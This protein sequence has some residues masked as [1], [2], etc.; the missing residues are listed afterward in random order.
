MSKTRDNS[1]ELDYFELRRRH[2][3]YKRA[4]SAPQP[5][6]NSVE[7]RLERQVAQQKARPEPVAAEQ[8]PI[9]DVQ[10]ELDVETKAAPMDAFEEAIEENYEAYEDDM[11]YDE[12][13]E[14]ELANPNPFD[15]FI[16]FFNGMKSNMASRR[17]KDDELEDLD[18]EDLTDEELAELEAEGLEDLD[19]DFKEEA[20]AP[21]KPRFSLRRNV[22]PDAEDDED[23]IAPVED[24]ED[25][26]DLPRPARKAAPSIV[27][28]DEDF[29]D[30]DFDDLDDEDFDD[31][32]FDDEDFDEEDFDEE[33]DAPRKGGFK[34]FVNLFVTR[35]DE[36][37]EFD[38]DDEELEDADFDD[39]DDEDLEEIEE[40]EAPVR[41]G[42]FS[43]VRKNKARRIEEDEEIYDDFSPEIQIRPE[44]GQGKMDEMNKLANETAAPAD[45]IETSGMSRRERRELAMRLAAEEAARKAEE[46]ALAKAAAAPV[47]PLFTDLE[48]KPAPVDMAAFED[49]PETD[50]IVETT[51]EEVTETVDEPT[52]EFTPVSMR[53]VQEAAEKA[54]FD[55]D[56]EEEDPDDEDEDDEDE[57]IVEK[58]PRRGLFGR[59]RAKVEDEDEED[60]DDEDDEDDDED[61]DDEEEEI[62]EKK[63]RRGLFGRKRAKDEDED[64]EDDFD[65][66]D[67]DDEDLD[68][69]EDDEYDEYD[70]DEDDDDYGD[71]DDDDEYDDDYD[72]DDDED[73]PRRSFGHHLIGVFKIILGLILVLLIVVIGLNFHYFITGENAVV[74]KAHEMLGDSSAS[75]VLC[76]GYVMREAMPAEETAAPEAVIEAEITAEPT[77][78]PQVEADIPDLDNNG[79]I[80]EAPVV[81]AAPVIEAVPAVGEAP[82]ASGT[83]G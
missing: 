75:D 73:E 23:E 35:V 42:F 17:Q 60:L 56:G 63:P 34:K 47:E 58:K 62:V 27:D 37:E 14:E 59:K 16:R 1:P 71:D 44:G 28:E 61:E 81:E 54:L 79:A 24:I 33:D 64:E 46:E 74:T 25:I 66:E 83:I 38:E 39:E 5:V 30:S 13:A 67:E 50:L 78:L 36:D 82:V 4:R 26:D 69:E 80:T 18:L 77:A 20:P 72:D 7:E 51:A 6:K 22:Q 32:D 41:K 49:A 3:E 10:D 11:D 29:D 8:A 21:A 76:F 31:E 40:D 43:R 45:V 19:E 55:V 12:E 65:D 48:V 2:E 15:S 68:D 52:R 53:D 9:N 70:D 57:E